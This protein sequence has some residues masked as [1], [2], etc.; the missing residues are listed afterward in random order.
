MSKTGLRWG[1]STDVG[2]IRQINQ[3][4]VMANGTLFAVADGMGGHRG[5]EVASEI[6]AGHF[7]I[8]ERI[9]T[10]A[11]LEGAVV[12]ANEMIW[13]RAAADPDLNGMGTTIVA[14]GV[15]PMSEADAPLQ[16]GAVN[17]GD[18]RLYLFE[19]EKLSQVSIDHSLV[20]ELTRAG[21]LTEEEAARHPQRNVVTRALGAESKVAVDSWLMPARLGQRYLMCSDGLI[22]EVS[23]D[24][25]AS[26]LAEVADPEAAANR[27]TD[28]A[29]RSGGRDNITVLIVD[30][31][32]A[33]SC[34]PAAT[35][36]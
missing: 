11:E 32:D 30:V 26:V 16:I 13:A 22:N 17:V 10:L 29:N 33:E 27:L 4:A 1:L 25:V 19:N 18:S 35:T 14:M 21:Q 36:S 34:D 31:V 20:G 9:S 8:V 12:L 3:D 7:R 23:D 5:G 15:L 24:V 28:L 6:A 2:M